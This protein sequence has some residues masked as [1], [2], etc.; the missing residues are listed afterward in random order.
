VR[1]LGLIVVL[2][3]AVGCPAGN[4]RV[5]PP[6]YADGGAAALA[7]Y[8]ANKDGVLA[9]PELDKCP[10]LKASLAQVD[11][12]ADK[13]ITADEINAR[14]GAW[15]ESRVGEIPVRVRVTLDGEPLVGAEVVFD[16]EPFL[17]GAVPSAHGVTIAGGVVGMTIPPE[18]LADPKFGGVPCGWY[19]IRI[20]HPGKSLPAK[21][22]TQSQ[23][24]CEIAMNA[25][26][27]SL[28]E[29]KLELVSK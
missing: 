10:G 7:E 22:N 11:T 12:N 8:D 4:G 17:G 25:H 15:R 3:S 18:R 20:T 23:L 1:S 26:W 5:V 29:I 14:I 21:Y 2:V 28:S 19:R 13:K 9:G 6:T 16:P 27:I 24:G